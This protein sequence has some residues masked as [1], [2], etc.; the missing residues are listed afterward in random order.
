MLL[1][2]KTHGRSRSQRGH[3]THSN[4][5]HAR[6]SLIGGGGGSDNT[7]RAT[8]RFFGAVGRDPSEQRRADGEAADTTARRGRDACA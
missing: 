5:T 4:T 8:G 2:L 1:L 6:R 3:R 7:R